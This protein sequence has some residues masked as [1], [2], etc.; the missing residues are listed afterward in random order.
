MGWYRRE[1]VVRVSPRA[2]VRALLVVLLVCAIAVGSL[3][4]FRHAA[5][6]AIGWQLIV[7]DPL[8]PADALVVLSGGAPE[9]ELEAADL[10]K[11]GIAPMI[12][13]P[14]DPERHGLAI[15][16]ERGVAIENELEFRQRVL[17]GL[18]VPAR[19]IVVLEPEVVSTAGEAQ[20]VVE[21]A[22]AHHARSLIIVTSAYH[23][24]RARLTYR[25]VIAK[26]DLTVR[27]RAARV[28]TYRADAWWHS[29]VDLRDGLIEWQK[30][31]FYRLW[32]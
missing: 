1:L 30:Q 3:Y 19:A 22:L 14:H 11:A 16:R 15:V 13:L 27:T 24:G 18:G 28:G 31:V 2:A 21:W 29:R 32:Y 4:V 5:L 6:T 12:L 7:D 10:Y 23:T 17:A 20:V 8:E 25:R 9:R 26:R